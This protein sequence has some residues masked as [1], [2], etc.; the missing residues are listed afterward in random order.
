MDTRP[1]PSVLIVDDYAETAEL[2][3]LLLRDRFRV[4][5]ALTG[6]SALARIR[7]DRPDVVLLDLWLPDGVDVIHA[8]RANED[9]AGTRV[10]ISTGLSTGS[11]FLQAQAT[12]CTILTKP[13]PIQRLMRALVPALP[14]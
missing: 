7:A 9:L 5:T 1:R 2:L 3:S 12:G 4:T 6:Q 13:P 11:L 14:A 10:V 8:I